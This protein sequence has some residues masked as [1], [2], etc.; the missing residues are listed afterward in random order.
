MSLNF[1]ENIKCII[2]RG[3]GEVR[4]KFYVFEFGFFFCRVDFV[5][6]LN[7]SIFFFFETEFNRGWDVFASRVEFLRI[8]EYIV[9]FGKIL[10][11]RLILLF[12]VIWIVSF[13]L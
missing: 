13:F 2:K 10:G 11:W 1:L 9:V 4:K 6:V 3:G 12:S 5:R 8:T 7:D